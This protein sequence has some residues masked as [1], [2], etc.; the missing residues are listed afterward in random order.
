MEI[1][2]QCHNRMTASL[3]LSEVEIYII[4]T[5]GRELLIDA[6][7]PHDCRCLRYLPLICC[8]NY[9]TANGSSSLF[10]I[11]DLGT[12]QINPNLTTSPLT[13]PKT[14]SL[15]P[16]LRKCL[17]KQLSSPVPREVSKTTP[18][19]SIPALLTKIYCRHRS[20]NCQVPPHLPSIAQR[21]RD[22][23]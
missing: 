17:P 21:R 13:H 19:P 2:I 18:V 14:C 4:I 1:V 16:G 9:I 22:R 20:R 11:F 8:R 23:S 7:T 12:F 3:I 15:K 10:H 5:R 6:C